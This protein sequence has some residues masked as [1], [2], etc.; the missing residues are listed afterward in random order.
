MVTIKTSVKSVKVSLIRQCDRE[1]RQGK[2]SELRA[3]SLGQ[4]D[5]QV[6]QLEPGSQREDT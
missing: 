6:A 4:G 5:L 2:S 1:S 3:E